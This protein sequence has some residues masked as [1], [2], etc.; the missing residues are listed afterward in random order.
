MARMGRRGGGDAK[1]QIT[2]ERNVGEVRRRKLGE[3]VSGTVPEVGLHQVLGGT[4]A[5]SL[6]MAESGF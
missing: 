6:E 2:K 1:T 3:R 4:E 5:V